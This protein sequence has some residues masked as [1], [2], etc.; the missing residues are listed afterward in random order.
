M[1]VVFVGFDAATAARDTSAVFML[2]SMATTVGGVFFILRTVLFCSG[3]TGIGI[4]FLI[5]GSGT[6]AIIGVRGVVAAIFTGMVVV[7]LIWVISVVVETVLLCDTCTVLFCGFEKDERS[8][9]QVR[10]RMAGMAYD[11]D[12]IRVLFDPST[13]KPPSGA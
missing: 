12:H 6:G 2:F 3:G 7:A 13:S 10:L 5:V 9:D 4:G 11:V 1:S 8:D